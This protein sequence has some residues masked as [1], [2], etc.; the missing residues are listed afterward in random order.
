MWTLKQYSDFSDV[1]RLY[2]RRY[3]SLNMLNLYIWGP[4]H[5]IYCEVD[6]ISQGYVANKNESDT[7]Q[8]HDI[9][10][11]E[12]TCD[13]ILYSVFAVSGHLK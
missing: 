7:Q 10:P 1:K 9:P 12:G 5:E 6:G 11:H 13:I 4:I 3:W 8:S 2:I